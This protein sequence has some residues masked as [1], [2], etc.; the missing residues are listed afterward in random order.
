MLAESPDLARRL[1]DI[2][3]LIAL[4]RARAARMATALAGWIL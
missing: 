3:C 4:K 1:G 2:A